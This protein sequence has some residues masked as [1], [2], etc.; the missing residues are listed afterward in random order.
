ML[1]PNDIS[2]MN[3]GSCNHDFS[4]T[5]LQLESQGG[6]CPHCGAAFDADELKRQ[7]SRMRLEWKKTLREGTARMTQMLKP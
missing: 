1:G 7:H 2:R 6:P 5:V 4:M 3:C